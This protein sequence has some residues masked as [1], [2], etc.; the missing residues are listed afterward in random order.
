MASPKIIA[1]L[2]LQLA[3][4]TAVGATSATLSADVDSDG[5]ALPTGTYYFTIDSGNS[6]KEYI[7]CTKTG[8]ALTSIKAVSRQGVETSGMVYAH[9]VAAPVIMTDFASYKSYI[10]EATIAGISPATTTTLGGVNT[11]TNTASSVVVS[12]DDVRVPSA[13]PDTLY[14]PLTAFYPIGSIYMSVVSTNPN[15]LFGFGTWTA[16]GAGRVPVGIDAG[17]TEF[18]TVEETGGAK[19]HTLSAA[20]M[21]SHTH[22]I[23]TANSSADADWAYPNDGMT[24]IRTTS[25]AK[26][27]VNS[28]GSGSAHNNLQPYI[29]C[30][31]WKRTA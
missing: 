6:N 22:T 15:T 30:Y 26:N 8:T 29:V 21:P 24:N 3:A 11:T 28:A 10:D 19:T 20:E 16:W 27:V 14:V 25:S 23:Y 2:R 12:T 5:V 4:K 13:D 9:N 7:S 1:D 17:Q 31:M 18:D